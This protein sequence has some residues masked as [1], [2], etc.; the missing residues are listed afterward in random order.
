MKELKTSIA[1]VGGGPG[2]LAAALQAAQLGVKS[3]I[4]DKRDRLGGVM[5]GGTGPFAAGT[6][7]QRRAREKFTAQDA[8]R[9]FME[10]SHWQTDPALVAAFV[11]KTADT[12][13]WL[14]DVGCEFEN[15]VCYVNGGYHTWHENS[16]SKGFISDNIWK[17]A[18]A[19]GVEAYLNT[20]VT[21]LLKENGKV[22]G[23][24]AEDKDGEQYR[25]R[26]DAV[27]V[28]TG[29]FGSN[30]EMVREF[31]PYEL[32]KTI[33]QGAA[34]TDGEGLKMMWE[35]GAFQDRQRMMMD[36]HVNLIDPA[37]KNPA[38]MVS[39]DFDA[40]KQPNLMVNSAGKRFTNEAVMHNGAH[41]INVV[42]QQGEI[43]A[44]M[45]LSD[46]IVDVYRKNGYD[47]LLPLKPPFQDK[48]ADWPE[49]FE[50]AV[51]EVD[52]KSEDVHCADSIRELA[53]KAG[54]DP[55]ALEQTVAE[56]NAAC[57]AGFDQAF[58]KEREY[59]RPIRG[60]RFFIARFRASAFCS[61]GGVQINARAEVLDKD[62]QPIPGLYASGNDANNLCYDTYS[63]Y[64]SGLTSSFALNMGRIAGESAVAAI[65]G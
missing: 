40:F 52:G 60:K 11:S 15:V 62:K 38:G 31:T 33:V 42:R 7:Q 21:K 4:F 19:L 29:G 57:D 64:T 12:I 56:Y 39:N 27:V 55:D 65:R 1:I 6:I 18:S 41:A 37:L 44:Y 17:A 25:V 45:I 35:V 61:M 49:R 28:S 20:K 51:A 32:G 63:F 24:L 10:W 8:F 3:I 47:V 26:A 34:L 9:F 23:L 59:L 2:G 22:C 13:R 50:E 14:E 48:H 30:P 36:A 43:G 58:L 5:F 54:I 46:E 16:M 53:E